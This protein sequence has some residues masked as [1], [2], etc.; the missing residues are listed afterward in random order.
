[1]PE[2]RDPVEFERVS[3]VFG[4]TGWVAWSTAT[5]RQVGDRWHFDRRGLGTHRED[6]KKALVGAYQ[7]MADAKRDSNAQV[8]LIPIYELRET[9]AFQCRVADDVVDRVLGALVTRADTFDNYVV[10]LHLAD[11]REFAP[12]ARPFRLNDKRY[13]Y[14]TIFRPQETVPANG[15]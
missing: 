6:V 7:R 11:L 1:M 8:P 13:Y 5:F 3:H 12:S 2:P 10:Q 4:L 9:T 14:V 15:E